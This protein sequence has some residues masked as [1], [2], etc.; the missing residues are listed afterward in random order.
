MRFNR[1]YFPRKSVFYNS[2]KID[3]YRSNTNTTKYLSVPAGTD[4]R[5][6]SF[7]ADFDKDLLRLSVFKSEHEIYPDVPYIALD[8]RDV[9]RQI[10]EKGYATHGAKVEIK[11]VIPS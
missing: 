3:I 7:P 1:L 6:M 8:A 10:Q 2:M 9:I 5:N 4:V 11:I